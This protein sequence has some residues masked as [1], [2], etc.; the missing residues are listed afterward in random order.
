MRVYLDTNFFIRL[1]EGASDRLDRVV[2]MADAGTIELVTS[3][4]TIAELLVVPLRLGKTDLVETYEA[5]LS[6]DGFIGVLPITRDL[7]RRSATIRATIG[8]KGMDAIH[9][10]TAASTGC[11]V[12]LS[13][14]AGIRVPP[15]MN[16]VTLEAI[17]AGE[18]LI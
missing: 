2:D 9:V 11:S 7:L 6:G 15:R 8:N 4:L 12:F 1:V 14:D 18:R 13:S 17:E 16:L 5:L 3:E 10:A